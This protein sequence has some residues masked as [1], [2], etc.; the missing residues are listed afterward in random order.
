M[1]KYLAL[2]AMA[3][4][5]VAQDYPKN[6]FEV[7]GGAGIPL[8]SHSRILWDDS[9][10]FSAGYGFRF[11]RHFQADLMYTRVSSPAETQFA[12][13]ELLEG[14]KLGGG[15]IDSYLLGGRALFPIG[16]RVVLSAGAGAIYDRFNAP[17]LSLGPN[18]DQ[19]GWGAYLLGSV[20]V[21][22]GRSKH[23][24]VTVTPR[25]EAVQARDAWL[26]RNRWLTLP[27]QF[28]FRL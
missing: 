2:S 16:S 24:Y 18:L 17:R 9:G 12:E 27:L 8:F 19:T 10:Q 11:Q 5:A 28:G 23:F 13:F 7:G 4:V 22:L 21:P 1:Y 6:S 26:H 20:S 25:F 3:M 15:T 14:H